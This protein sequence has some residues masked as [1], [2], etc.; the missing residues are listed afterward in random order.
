MLK[1]KINNGIETVV[2]FYIVDEFLTIVNLIM[3]VLH[4]KEFEQLPM[5]M[6]RKLL[7][8]Y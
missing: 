2:Q 7:G 3:I 6:P 5:Q 1:N 4:K 8:N